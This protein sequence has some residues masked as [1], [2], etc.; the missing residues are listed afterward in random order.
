MTSSPRLDLSTTSLVARTARGLLDAIRANDDQRSRSEAE[1]LAAALGVIKPDAQSETQGVL[2]LRGR[3]VSIPQREG[4]D[5]ELCTEIT[6]EP[7][8]DKSNRLV[9]DTAA[10]RGVSL[11]NVSFQLEESALAEVYR[12]GI[13]VSIPTEIGSA[14]TTI[15]RPPYAYHFAEPHENPPHFSLVVD[16]EMQTNRSF[17]TFRRSS[18]VER[19]GT[20]RGFHGDGDRVHTSEP[21]AS[22][23][24]ADESVDLVFEG[25]IPFSLTTRP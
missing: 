24:S 23:R 10:R 8:F 11:A 3:V 18:E 1:E 7:Y 17:P 6:T 9:V 14:W 25:S 21:R 15:T 22:A 19:R 20:P 4:F 5:A 13:P 16:T 2:F 12:V